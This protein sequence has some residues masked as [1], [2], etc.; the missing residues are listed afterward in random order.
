MGFKLGGGN[1]MQPYDSN[2]GQYTDKEL[3]KINNQ[4]MKN[5][6][7]VHIYGFND[8]E[9]IFHFPNYK[10]HTKEYCK[11]FVEYIRNFINNDDVIIENSKMV[12]LLTKLKQNDKSLFLQNIGYNTNDLQ[13]LMNDIRKGT[14]FKKSEFKII[15]E[16]TFNIQAK[17]ILKG[18]VVTTAWQLKEDGNVRLITLIPGGNKI[19]K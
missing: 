10:I 13:E 5:L 6:A 9:L 12:Y 3:S 19:W 15:R 14:N 11:L 2:N 1:H 7:L 18:Y 8:K 16:T 17:T 4:D